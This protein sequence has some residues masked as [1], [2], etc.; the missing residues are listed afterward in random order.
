M[1]GY[2]IIKM[3]NRN[4]VKISVLA[5]DAAFRENMHTIKCIANQEYNNK[6][7]DLEFLWVDFY[8]S[9][10]WVKDE[11]AKHKNIRL[12]TLDNTKDKKWHLGVCVN[13]GV[14]QSNGDILVILDGDIFLDSDFITY[15]HK[16]CLGPDLVT[17]FRRFDEPE[18]AS[19][20]LSLHKIRYLEEK[21]VLTNPTNYA[22]CFALRKETFNIIK[23]YEEHIVF[24]GPGMN[25]MEAYIRFR[26][27]GLSIRWA[28]KKI[29]H[30]W[31]DSTGLSDVML[32]E[33]Q[34]LHDLKADF[35]WINV[36][37]GVGQSWVTH[38][39]EMNLD[40]QAC[41]KVADSYLK[42]LPV[43]LT[44]FCH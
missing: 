7:I 14:R 26:N 3:F 19:C 24:S 21:C 38:R 37:S 34:Q 13:E 6:I 39:R 9:N 20:D 5:W 12:I 23:G 33:R 8:S 29:Y 16:H 44:R 27:A 42:A 36:Y 15:V 28:T 43:G 10:Q 18:K 35:P 11:V 1:P 30:P 31:H 22:G 41:S 2:P 25:A 17:Y 4:K 40:V 32:E